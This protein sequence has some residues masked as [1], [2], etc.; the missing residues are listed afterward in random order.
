MLGTLPAD[1]L[2][3]HTPATTFTI[4]SRD[5]AVYGNVTVLQLITTPGRLT[6]KTSWMRSITSWLPG[7]GKAVVT[8]VQLYQKQL[9][10]NSLAQI[11]LPAR[12]PYIK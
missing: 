6:S 1:N 5:Y 4:L 9:G 3:I 8:A 12:G 10:A 2:P 7:P 11:R